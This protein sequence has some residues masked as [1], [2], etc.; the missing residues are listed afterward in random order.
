MV[1]LLP[2]TLAGEGRSAPWSKGGTCQAQH[3]LLPGHTMAKLIPS[4]SFP[5]PPAER[6]T[7]QAH[8]SVQTPLPTSTCL[9]TPWED[10][11]RACLCAQGAQT[12]RSWEPGVE[13]DASWTRNQL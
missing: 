12:G 9:Q 4:P 10:E 6:G 5:L 8:P 3:H 11:G 1:V 7:L 2:L 13:P